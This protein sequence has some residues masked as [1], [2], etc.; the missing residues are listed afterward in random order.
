M[1]C[2]DNP[3]V[4][5]DDPG[6]LRLFSVLLVSPIIDCTS[7]AALNAACNTRRVSL[8]VCVRLYVCVYCGACMAGVCYRPVAVRCGMAQWLSGSVAVR[9]DVAQWL[10]GS[11][12]VW[13]GM[14]QWLCDTA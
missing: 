6:V 11:V 5:D 3:A 1:L 14:A 9:R 2:V 8:C 13:R 7:G 4:P 12:A 10:H